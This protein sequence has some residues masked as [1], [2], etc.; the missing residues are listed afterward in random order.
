[1]IETGRGFV[2]GYNQAPNSHFDIRQTESLIVRRD[3]SYV[4]NVGVRPDVEVPVANYTENKFKQVRDAA[5]K[6]LE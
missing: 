6:A 2:G 1:M 3:G 5:I 4:E